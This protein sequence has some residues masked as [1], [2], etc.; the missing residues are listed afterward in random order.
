MDPKRSN[1]IK[2]KMQALLHLKL[3]EVVRINIPPRKLATPPG[4]C[5]LKSSMKA[6]GLERETTP[7][8]IKYLLKRIDLARKTS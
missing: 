5:S 1:K 2:I 8:R 3:M 4:S 7:G 6:L